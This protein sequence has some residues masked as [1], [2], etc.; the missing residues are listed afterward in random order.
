MLIIVVYTVLYRYL[1]RVEFRH[2][3]ILG[4]VDINCIHVYEGVNYI[5]LRVFAFKHKAITTNV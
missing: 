1:F 2:A 5:K 3:I 4:E